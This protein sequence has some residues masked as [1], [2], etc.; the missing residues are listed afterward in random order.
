[1]LAIV[2]GFIIIF[3]LVYAVCWVLYA[4]LVPDA[5]AALSMFHMHT[6]AFHDHYT[7]VGDGSLGTRTGLTLLLS[8]GAALLVWVSSLVLAQL[9]SDEKQKER[10]DSRLSLIFLLFA[11]YLIITAVFIPRRMVEYDTAARKMRVTDY[12]RVL[13]FVPNPLPVD[14]FEIGFDQLR[15]FRFDVYSEHVMAA[16][17]E[18]AELYA[19]TESDT[20]RVGKQL[21]YH[22]EFGWIT[23][24]R[25][26]E[27][28]VAAGQRDA[29]R[30]AAYLEN[31]VGIER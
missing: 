25:S 31:L 5:A 13:L 3:A 23:D 24:W 27:E 4:L 12:G 6:L 28:I 7:A 16:E 2:A 9:T 30:A 1:M 19:I 17:H 21:L 18:E 29:R 8:F 22:G 15:A 26:T 14:R 10:W 20:L 11:L